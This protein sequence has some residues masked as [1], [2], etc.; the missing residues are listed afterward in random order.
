MIIYDWICQY[1]IISH[2]QNSIFLQLLT[3]CYISYL[4]RFPGWQISQGPGRAHR[5]GPAQR[6]GLHDEGAEGGAALRVV[7]LL[8]LPAVGTHQ[9][10]WG[11]GPRGFWGHEQLSQGGKYH[12]CHDVEIWAGDT[13]D[14]RPC[15]GGSFEKGAMTIRNNWPIGM[16]VKWSS[17]ERLRLWCPPEKSK[18]FF[19]RCEKS[20]METN[21][22]ERIHA[23]MAG[24]MNEWRTDWL[25]EWVTESDNE[26]L[27]E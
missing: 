2:T 9:F 4:H 7:R 11:C 10:S 22:H 6:Q 8:Q 15:R 3:S 24:W 19:L 18:L 14:A 5:G 1:V 25:T 27:S 16:H 21:V 20:D 12:G 26:S 13:S 23:R 17:T